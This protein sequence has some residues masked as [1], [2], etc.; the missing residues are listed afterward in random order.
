MK[1][2]AKN[3]ELTIAVPFLISRLKLLMKKLLLDTIVHLE[4]ILRNTM[5][6]QLT[7]ELRAKQLAIMQEFSCLGIM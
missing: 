3:S 5:G 2:A 4:Y 6:E 7:M 1:L